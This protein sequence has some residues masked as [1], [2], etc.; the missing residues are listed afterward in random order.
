[1]LSNTKPGRECFIVLHRIEAFLGELG[2]Q[3]AVTQS[4]IGTFFALVEV[5][6]DWL[7]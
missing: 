4:L 5:G 7:A 6:L 3:A 2:V 1:M